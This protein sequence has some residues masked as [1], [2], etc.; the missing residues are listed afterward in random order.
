M[1]LIFQ[2]DTGS[3]NHLFYSSHINLITNLCIDMDCGDKIGYF[4]DKFLGPPQKIKQ[5]R[6]PKKPT[7][8]KSSYL[9]YCDEHRKDIMDTK[10]AVGEKIIIGDISKILGKNWHDLSINDKVVYKNLADK[11]KNRY[12]DEMQEYN[13]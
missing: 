11:D 9:Y 3:L 7:R 13:N 2:N 12:N 10:R 1:S 8:P 6:D 5:R 4:V